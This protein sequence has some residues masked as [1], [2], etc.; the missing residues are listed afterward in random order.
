MK[1][2]KIGLVCSKVNGAYKGP[3]F[4]FSRKRGWGRKTVIRNRKKAPGLLC[5]DIIKK[6]NK[7]LLFPENTAHPISIFTSQKNKKV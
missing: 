2:L 3:V 4:Y 6:A 7:C 5:S 1:I